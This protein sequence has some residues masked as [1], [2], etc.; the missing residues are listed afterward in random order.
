[1]KS[2]VLFFSMGMTL[3]GSSHA[4]ELITAEEAAQNAQVP[5]GYTLRQTGPTEPPR[6]IV[7]RPSGQ[8][9]KNPVEIDIRFVPE[10]GTRV[11]PASLRILYGWMGIDITERIRQKAKITAQ[12]IT[13]NGA[14]LPAG[15][16]T[17]TIQIADSRQRVGQTEL[18]FRIE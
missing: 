9:L 1:M 5:E 2:I 17:L 16:H 4:F 13:A 14:E 8:N 18:S 10:P 12:G 3:W 15:H 11:N 6:V 7:N